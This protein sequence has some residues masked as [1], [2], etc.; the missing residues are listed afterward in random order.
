MMRDANLLV[1]GHR[2][3]PPLLSDRLLATLTPAKRL[4]DL[5]FF[6]IFEADIRTA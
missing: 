5:R 3:N 2:I 4:Q 1:E 6:P